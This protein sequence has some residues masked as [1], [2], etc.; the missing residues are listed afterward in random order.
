MDFKTL[1]WSS[2]EIIVVHVVV[3]G[4][5]RTRPNNNRGNAHPTPPS[6]D[7]SDD[8]R[9]AHRSRTCSLAAGHP[10][11]MHRSGWFVPAS[12]GRRPLSRIVSQDSRL[13]A[14][15]GPDITGPQ[16]IGAGVDKR[17]IT[18]ICSFAVTIAA[19]R[20]RYVCHLAN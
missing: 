9:I 20:G 13:T 10:S 3:N 8:R 17:W 18:G 4:E 5:Q 1:H 2:R 7:T 14:C 15:I 19:D 6:I 11:S 16:K 12:V